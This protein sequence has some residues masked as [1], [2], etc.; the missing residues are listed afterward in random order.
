MTRNTRKKTSALPRSFSNTTMS[1]ATPHMRSSG[2]SVRMSGKR[3]G[4]T[5]QVNTES[6]SRFC[7][8]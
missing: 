4:P 6:I 1:I 8:R 2:R 3:N 7:A 5:C